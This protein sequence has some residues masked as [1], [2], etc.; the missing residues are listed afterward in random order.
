[1]HKQNLAYV[2]WTMFPMWLLTLPVLHSSLPPDKPQS[3]PGDVD[4]FT[5]MTPELI[6]SLRII[7]PMLTK[8]LVCWMLKETFSPNP[9]H[10]TKHSLLI[11]LLQLKVWFLLLDN[12]DNCFLTRVYYFLAGGALGDGSTDDSDAIQAVINA[13][14]N[15]KVVYFPAGSYVIGKTVT[16][17]PGTRIIGE[18]WS[19]LMAG[20]A[21]FQ[22]AM[23]P[24][25]M[26]KVGNPGQTGSVE[27]TDLFFASK[28]WLQS[29]RVKSVK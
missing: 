18:T 25:P 14:V 11:S 5:E 27:I 8:I 19:V 26:I 29:K 21:A 12:R 15:G 7:F 23:N 16:V 9:D 2:R 6:L 13:N 3:H 20:G 10:N 4:Q 22:D 1:M 17:P 24:Q 28:V